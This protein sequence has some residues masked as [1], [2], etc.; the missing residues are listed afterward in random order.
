M[1]AVIFCFH[2]YKTHIAVDEVDD[3]L[4]ETMRDLI[5][6]GQIVLHLMGTGQLVA[7]HPEPLLLHHRQVGILHT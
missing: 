4:E 3:V 2:F 7:G 1:L 5:D 6:G